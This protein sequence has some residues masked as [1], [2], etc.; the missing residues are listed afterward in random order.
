MTQTLETS[1]TSFCITFC[2]VHSSLATPVASLFLELS[3][4]ASASVLC[5]CCLSA[6]KIVPPRESHS[7][8]SHLILVSAQ[9]SPPSRS[10]PDS[11]FQ[12]GIRPHSPLPCTVFLP[13]TFHHSTCDFHR[14]G[15]RLLGVYSNRQLAVL[16]AQVG[17]DACWVQ[18][19]WSSWLV[20]WLSHGRLQKSFGQVSLFQ[21]KSCGLLLARSQAGKGLELSFSSLR[22]FPPNS[23]VFSCSLISVGPGA[24]W[25]SLIQ[26]SQWSVVTRSHSHRA[27]GKWNM[28]MP[29]ILLLVTSPVL[30]LPSE[31]LGASGF[32]SF[33]RFCQENRLVSHWCLPL[34]AGR[35]QPVH[36]AKSETLL[37]C[38]P[39]SNIPCFSLNCH[40]FFSHATSLWVCTFFI[41]LLW[42][43]GTWDRSRVRHRCDSFI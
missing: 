28:V 25:L 42:L 6:C 40:C 12:N 41:P 29:Q 5:T 34:Q 31:E 26:A 23:P 13:S 20:I 9:I 22:R 18:L 3:N 37:I 15:R 8:I 16:C 11:S 35:D 21:K 7:T 27:E 2:S 4:Y 14:F 24:L 33:L 38:F 32:W 39:S 36:S 19:W 43:G 30:L 1:L 10:F 17:L